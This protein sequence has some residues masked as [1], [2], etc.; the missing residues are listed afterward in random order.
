MKAL[1]RLAKGEYGDPDNHGS[2]SKAAAGEN[3]DR[4]LLKHYL[5]KPDIRAGFGVWK[6]ESAAAQE[7]KDSHKDTGGTGAQQKKKFATPA[8]KRRAFSDAFKKATKLKAKG[9]SATKASEKCKAEFGAGP[10]ATSINKAVRENR[11]G[12]SPQKGGRQPLIPKEA[13]QKLA[14]LFIWMREMKY[15]ILKITVMAFLVTLVLGTPLY[16]HFVTGAHADCNQ[17]N[18]YRAWLK[19]QGLST[20]SPNSLAVTRAKWVTAANAKTHYEVLQ[21]VLLET[22]RGE[23]VSCHSGN[24]VK[25]STHS[26]PS[27]I[28]RSRLDVCC[29]SAATMHGNTALVGLLT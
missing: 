6:Q 1:L 28:R 29:I 5:A 4:Q 14:G 19:R 15:T 16:M 23:N 8:D 26:A 10:G 9:M 3:V 27:A 17:N 25:I 2:I 18:W 13:E 11:I 24:G 7:E 22:G 21:G 12:I 20:V